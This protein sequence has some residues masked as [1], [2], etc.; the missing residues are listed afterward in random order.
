MRYF[1]IWLILFLLQ[2]LQA[3]PIVFAPLPL[4]NTHKSF[5]DFN[6][7]IT[8]L[9]EALG[10]TIVFRYEKKYD[11]IVQLFQANEI[12]IAYL[13]P[14]PYAVLQ[15]HFPFAKPIVTFHEKDGKNGYRCALVQFSN[16]L[17]DTVQKKA[18]KVALAQPFSTCGYTQT[19]LLLERNSKLNLDD[20]QF[21]YLGQYDEVAL[22][23]IR[24]DFTL[25]GM[26]ENIA[27]SYASLGLKILEVSPLL[28]GFSLIVNTKTLTEKEI[29]TI[30]KQLLT[31]S[32]EI[33]Q[34]WGK[35]ISYGM[36]EAD[37]T[38]FQNIPISAKHFTIPTNGNF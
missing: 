21:R 4:S 31:T 5:D 17:I 3:R 36:S 11:D 15:Q 6:P 13:G 23:I 25:G 16:K 34:T 9:E 30:K 8:H 27:H 37:E 19:K 32:Q 7:M 14:F 35:D 10:K 20:I 28:P 22:S 26:K 2:H 12:D 24:G 38:L 33:Y 18:P 1:S 29:D